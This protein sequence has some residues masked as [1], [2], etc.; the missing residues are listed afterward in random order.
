[1]RPVKGVI[2]GQRDSTLLIMIESGKIIHTAKKPG[3]VTGKPVLVYYDFTTSKVKDVQLEVKHTDALEM[4]MSEPE[5]APITGIDDGIEEIL[6]S[7]VWFPGALRPSC[8]G[9]WNPVSG[10]FEM[11]IPDFEE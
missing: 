1:M 3:L 4:E 8:D 7:G 9:F 11:E 6:D 2:T 10:L 5:E